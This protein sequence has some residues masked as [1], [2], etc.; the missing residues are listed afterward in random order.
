M[1]LVCGLLGVLG[2]CLEFGFTWD[3]MPKTNVPRSNAPFSTLCACFI[4]LMYAH[5]LVFVIA[6]ISSA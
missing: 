6:D 5:V 4:S 1:L 2:V 3:E